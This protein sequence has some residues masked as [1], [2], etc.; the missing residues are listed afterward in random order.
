VRGV[1]AVDASIVRALDVDDE[2]WSG[3]K[4]CANHCQI[5]SSQRDRS[6]ADPVDK[7]IVFQHLTHL[8]V[9]QESAS[10]VPVFLCDE[11]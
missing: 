3:G 11:C 4:S 8:L 5:T 10:Y 1:E 2:S 9:L 7:I 6:G